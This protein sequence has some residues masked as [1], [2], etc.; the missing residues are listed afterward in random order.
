MCQGY[1]DEFGDD[2]DWIEIHN[3]SADSVL[4]SDYYLSDNP[5]NLDKWQFPNT[6]LGSKEILTICASGRENMR[7]PNHRESLV[8]AEN[9]WKYWL[10]SSPPTSDWANWNTLAFNDQNWNSGQGGIGYGDN[11]D[12]T[13]IAVTPSLYLRKEFEINDLNDITQLLFHAD[14]DDG[15]IAYLNG[16]EIMRSNNFNSFNPGYTELTNANHEA[17]LYNG[18]IPE[19]K[20]F[21]SDEISEILVQGANILAIQIHN[22]S[23]TSSDMSGNFFLLRRDCLNNV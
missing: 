3:Y 16:I 5:N 19:S 7:L 23:T 22:A 6:Y 2:V 13:I 1:T 10:G 12:N 20:F 14:Y 17:V 11:D 4:L 8:M 21:N 15:F 9:T 18:G